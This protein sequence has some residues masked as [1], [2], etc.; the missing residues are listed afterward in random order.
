MATAGGFCDFE[1]E[2]TRELF[3]KPTL[4]AS[5]NHE[6]PQK[7]RAEQSKGETLLGIVLQRTGTPRA[8]EFGRL[9]R[10]GYTGG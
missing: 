10:A 6:I 7:G 5:K 8:R 3:Q 1:T 4:Y 9:P 2:R